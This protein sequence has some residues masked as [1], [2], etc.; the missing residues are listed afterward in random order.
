[1]LTTAP[2][3]PW[4][5]PGVTKNTVLGIARKIGIPVAEKFIRTEEILAADEVMITST[6]IDII[7]VAR[8]GETRIGEGKPGAVFKALNEAYR[9]FVSST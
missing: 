1:M 2:D 5:L 7:P 8:I 6:R 3:G 4:I 9:R